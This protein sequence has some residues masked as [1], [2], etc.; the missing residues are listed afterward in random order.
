MNK[1]LELW[2]GEFGDNYTKRNIITDE[3]LNARKNMWQGILGTALNVGAIDSILEVGA[4]A[5]IN[6]QAISEVCSILDPKPTLHAMEPNA[7][8]CSLLQEQGIAKS[9]F[10]YNNLSGF[11]SSSFD[12]VF[13]SGVLIHIH[14]DD[15]LKQM[16]DIYRIA[17][18]FVLCIE[19]F[20]PE[21]REVPYRGQEGALWANDFGGLYLDNFPLQCLGCGF[22]W[23]RITG[24]DNLTWTLFRKVN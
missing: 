4:G 8:A 10:S 14:P 11:D 1:N 13:T 19:Y 23:R 24:L 16:T 18:R 6:I 12:M 22:L 9:I 2:K 15:L 3:Q 17:K 20:A 5:G 21:C 7:K